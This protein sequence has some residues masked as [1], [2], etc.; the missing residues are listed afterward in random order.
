MAALRS[1]FRCF[2]QLSTQSM[3]RAVDKF[4]AS[5]SIFTFFMYSVERISQSDIWLQSGI[6]AFPTY[7]ILL[8]KVPYGACRHGSSLHH[9]ID[10]HR[11]C[12]RCS[13]PFPRMVPCATSMGDPPCEN[14]VLWIRKRALFHKIEDSWNTISYMMERV[15]EGISGL[16][17]TLR[18]FDTTKLPSCKKSR[19]AHCKRS[20]RGLTS[21]SETF[22]H[23][24]KR[25]EKSNEQILSAISSIPKKRGG[26]IFESN[27]FFDVASLVDF[28]NELAKKVV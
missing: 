25:D 6:Q 24:N 8:R 20:P 22:F 16:D 5:L 1:R 15:L 28:W 21:K 23:V 2:P 14:S 3:H 11:R 4:R 9:A 17:I 26:R 18:N 12:P 10:G 19:T 13:L 7:L 27:G